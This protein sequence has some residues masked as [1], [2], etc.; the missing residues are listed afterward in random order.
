MG[1]FFFTNAQC[2]NSTLQSNSDTQK[3][4]WFTETQWAS[5]SFWGKKSGFSPCGWVSGRWWLDSAKTKLNIKDSCL[6][7]G[8]YQW[9]CQSNAVQPYSKEKNIHYKKEENKCIPKPSDEIHGTIYG[10]SKWPQTWLQWQKQSGQHL[11]FKHN[12]WMK[13]YQSVKIKV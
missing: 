9:W 1:L 7:E 13:F 6:D 11:L 8:G 12:H 5:L 2:N 4:C 10:K 3:I